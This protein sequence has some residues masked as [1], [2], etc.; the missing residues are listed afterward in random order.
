MGVSWLGVTQKLIFVIFRDAVNLILWKACSIFHTQ[1][2][3]KNGHW[4]FVG[5]FYWWPFL[6]GKNVLTAKFNETWWYNDFSK[7]NKTMHPPFF[8]CDFHWWSILKAILYGMQKVA[9]L[10]RAYVTPV[11]FI[12]CYHSSM[13]VDL[14]VLKIFRF[15][16]VISQNLLIAETFAKFLLSK[17]FFCI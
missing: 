2:A 11:S 4:A 14:V 7:E 16:L 13:S 17:I 1:A 9:W 3:M 12:L 10:W 5:G 15:K 8:E 6:H